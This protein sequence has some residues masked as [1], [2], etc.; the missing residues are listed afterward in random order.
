MAEPLSERGRQILEAII[1]EHIASAQPIGSKA[2]TRFQGIRFR[3]TSYNVCY[4]KLLRPS[5]L[6]MRCAPSP[7]LSAHC[8]L[9]PEVISN[10]FPSSTWLPSMRTTIGSEQCT[11]LA[12]SI[13]PWAMTSQ[14]MMPPKILTKIPFTSG[15]SY[16]FV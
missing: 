1:E 9:S 15:S 11:S 8:T 13:T 2:L 14:R 4:T 12:A 6:T 16:N 7:R 3:I 5:I 10:F